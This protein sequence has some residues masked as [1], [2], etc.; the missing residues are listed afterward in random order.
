MNSVT[1][2][3]NLGRQDVYLHVGEGDA[4]QFVAAVAPGQASRQLAPEG[5]RWSVVASETYMVT[6]DAQNAV[7]LIGSR[8]VF[9]VESTRAVASEGGELLQDAPYRGYIGDG[10]AEI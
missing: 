1:S 10:I 7:Y 2:F 8:G 5:T 3:V 6:S 4:M 9:S